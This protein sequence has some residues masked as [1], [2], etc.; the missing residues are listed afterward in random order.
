MIAFIVGVAALYA[1]IAPSGLAA[2]PLSQELGDNLLYFRADVLPRDLPPPDVKA[3]PLVLDLRFTAAENDAT[4]ALSAWL[5]LRATATAPVFLLINPGT[6]SNLREMLGKN[7]PRPGVI[8]IGRKS[9]DL[10]PDIEV[11]TSS[12]EERRAYEA[13]E[14]KTPI[15]SLLVENAD[16]PRV[17]EASIMRARDEAAE[18]FF[19]ANPLDD[20]TATEPKPEAK[21]TPP[22][23][24]TLQRAVH[25]H[26][27]LRALKRL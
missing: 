10:T 25:V 5:K 26:R 17:D 12:E 18:D 7:A 15:E 2:K 19:E 20:V 24:R 21:T 16:K 14:Q 4:T 6:A 9:E 3:G 13:L 27:A 23:D 11:A 8:T 1:L 22:I